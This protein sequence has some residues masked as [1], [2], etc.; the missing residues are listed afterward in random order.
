MSY[1][2]LP[3]WVG[4]CSSRNG[5][6]AGAPY[7]MW[8]G[9]SML[10]WFYRHGLEMDCSPMRPFGT[11]FKPSMANLGRGMSMLSRPDSPA[12]HSRLQESAIPMRTIETCGLTPF[13]LLEKSSLNGYSS[14]TSGRYSQQ[15]IKPQRHLIDTSEP[16]YE[17]WP[18]QGMMLDGLSFPLK[19]PVRRISERES[20]LL[21]TPVSKLFGSNTAMR[22]QN[23]TLKDTYLTWPTPTVNE[24]HNRK[25]A[26]PSSGDG[27]ATAVKK[28]RYP[29]PVS[30]AHKGST[31]RER[32]MGNP[33][34]RIQAEVETDELKLNPDWMEWLMGWP[35]GWTRLEPLPKK[36]FEQWLDLCET[37]AYWDNEPL[38]IAPRAI[39][40]K[41]KTPNRS[42]RIKA[43]GN[44]QVPQSAKLAWGLLSK[45]GLL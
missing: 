14:K 8:S 25:G 37:G 38:D 35:V 10:K 9:T 7:A 33:K 18:K 28:W 20:G 22:K 23:T 29:T 11:M 43:I 2:Y 19:M 45:G 44:G 3:G 12:N 27:L 16:F 39:P 13:A 40:R 1:V 30:S 31:K 17:N 36:R 5:S 15:W 26:S 24:N 41:Q 32:E 42:N 21:P 6:V 4:D 34:R